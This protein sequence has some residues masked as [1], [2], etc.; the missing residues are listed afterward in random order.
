LA[1]QTGSGARQVESF[2]ASPLDPHPSA[3]GRLA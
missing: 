1:A 3:E 2:L